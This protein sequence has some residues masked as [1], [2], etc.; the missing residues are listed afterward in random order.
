VMFVL[1]MSVL[2]APL[3]AGAQQPAPPD[4][5]LA[6][7]MEFCK[8]EVTAFEEFM[9]G[10]FPTMGTGHDFTVNLVA[11]LNDLTTAENVREEI[12]FY[13]D[14]GNLF[15]RANSKAAPLCMINLRLALIEGRH[16]ARARS[17]TDTAAGGTVASKESPMPAPSK[18]TPGPVADSRSKV[19]AE[20]VR[21]SKPAPHLSDDQKVLAEMLRQSKE[22]HDTY[23]QRQLAHIAAEAKRADALT[24][25]TF[26][27]DRQVMF[28]ITNNTDIKLAFSIDFT[29]IIDGKEESHVPVAFVVSPREQINLPVS[30]VREPHVFGGLR[31]IKSRWWA[32]SSNY[33]GP[34]NQPMQGN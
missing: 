18:N 10:S 12:L 8:P 31:A 15:V 3:T 22:A 13:Q 1:T 2:I 5:T 34:W 30:Y 7:V 21:K 24:V 14:P 25:E 9:V 16:L 11:N 20:K 23:R 32:D 27:D 4:L 17:A 29:L 6:Q 33:E 26:V 19:I 28:H